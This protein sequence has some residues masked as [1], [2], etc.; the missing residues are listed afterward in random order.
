MGHRG[1]VRQTLILALMVGLALG[2]APSWSCLQCDPSFAMQ[3]ASYIP[4]LSRKSW[5]I[6]DVPAAGRRLR[7]WAQDTLDEIRL[8]VPLEIPLEELQK[9]A[10]KTYSKLNAVFKGKTYKPGE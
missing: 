9:V 6:G 7:G 4:Q 1:R 5:G 8:D 3:F 2:P 10:V